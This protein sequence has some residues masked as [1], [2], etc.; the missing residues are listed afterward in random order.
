MSHRT[1][2]KWL[3]YAFC[4]CFSLNIKVL[5]KTET[6][7]SR[8]YGVYPFSQVDFLVWSTVITVLT[9]LLRGP[10]FLLSLFNMLGSPV[11]CVPALLPRAAPFFI[12]TLSSVFWSSDSRPSVIHV[13]SCWILAL[14]YK[15]LIFSPSWS[16]ED[17][18][19][20]HLRPVNVGF[21]YSPH[22]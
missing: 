22:F 2:Q 9:S 7:F 13:R 16:S 8:R 10:S 6:L 4:E 14:E 12:F 17:C 11:L 3:H 1:E 20:C 21:I 19:F 15:F 18:P 5:R